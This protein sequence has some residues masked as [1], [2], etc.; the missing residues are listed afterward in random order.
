MYPPHHYGGYET[1]CQEVVRRWSDA[2]HEV[3]VLTS[4]VQLSGRSGEDGSAT[5]TRALHMYW[6]DHVVLN[7]ARRTRLKWE[8]ANQ[9]ALRKVLDTF[10]PDVVSIWHL[11]GLSLA[12]VTTLVE[13]GVPIVFNVHDDWLYYAPQMDA[14]TRMFVERPRLARFVRGLTGVPT[15]RPDLGAAG[16]FCFVS[17]STRQRAE[18]RSAWRYSCATVVWNGIDAREFTA[19]ARSHPWRWQLLYAGRIDPRKGVDLAIRALA[20][21]PQ[22]ATLTIAGRGDEAYAAELRELVTELGLS[23]RVTF[24]EFDRDALVTAYAEADAV[25]FPSRW[26]EPFGLVPLEAMACRTPVVATGTGG[27]AE[28]CF[29]G[30][31]CLLFARDD[32]PGLCAALRRLAT[33]AD[34]RAALVDGGLTT[35]QELTIDRLAE[36]LEAWHVAAATRFRDGVPP[37]RPRPLTGLVRQ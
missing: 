33:D 4:D 16:A 18:Q 37:H 30:V 35:T 27:S 14:W 10:Q 26:E 8:R 2:G 24:V 11:A 1:T 19:P 3:H 20:D 5:V 22:T 12:L 31:N 9:Q 15:S 7:P 6:D 36:T 25:I 29:D 13:R 23:E 17:E 34:L 28:F 21:L 32:L